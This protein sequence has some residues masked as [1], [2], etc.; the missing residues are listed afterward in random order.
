MP[1]YKYHCVECDYTKTYFHDINDVIEVCE[2]C[3]KETMKKV[4]GKFNLKNKKNSS[5]ER[6]GSLTKKYIEE[7]RA[8]LE[9]QKKEAKEE[10]YESS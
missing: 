5:P 7:N 4:I 9:E 8:I 6:V 1:R 2:N 10:K 3:D